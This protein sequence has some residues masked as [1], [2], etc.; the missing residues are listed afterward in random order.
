MIDDLDKK[1][2]SER[3]SEYCSDFHAK[4]IHDLE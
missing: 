1:A 3:K 2:S 4:A